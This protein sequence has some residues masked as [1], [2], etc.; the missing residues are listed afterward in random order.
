MNTPYQN[1]TLESRISVV[2]PIL[3]VVEGSIC[4]RSISSNSFLFGLV[5]DSEFGAGVKAGVRE[6]A[7]LWIV[8]GFNS[9]CFHNV[10]NRSSDLLVR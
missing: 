4:G 9:Q 2:C 8:G 1:N 10:L 7:H 3:V 5:I 6:V